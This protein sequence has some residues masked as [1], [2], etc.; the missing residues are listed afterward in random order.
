[1]RGPKLVGYPPTGPAL[2]GRLLA[3]LFRVA[4]GGRRRDVDLGGRRAT[5]ASRASSPTRSAA[6]RRRSTAAG[7]RRTAAC[8]SSIAATSSCSTPSRARAARSR[9]P[10]ATKANPRWARRESAITFTRDNN[11][12]VVPL[13]SGEIAQLT[14]VQPRKRDPRDTDSQK[15][16]KAEEHEADRAHA[17]S[18]RRRRRRPRRRTRPT[19]CRSSSSPTG[20]RR[21]ICSSRPTAS[22]SSCSW[23]SA[24]TPPSGPTCRTTSPSRAT[25]RTSRRAPSSATRRTSRSLAVMNLDDRQDACSAPTDTETDE[26]HQGRA[27]LGDAGAVRRRRAGGGARARREQQGSLA[28]RRRSGERQGPRPRHAARRCVGARG[29]RLRPVDPSF[30][31]L[32][33]QKH[34]WFLS[35]RDGWMH[36]YSRRCDRARSRPR[37]S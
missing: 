26:G 19:R 5:A 1:M 3:P 30:G 15:F 22:T 21:P 13:D 36:L 35:E 20:S 12:F 11:L 17:R 28:G 8:S 7:T 32:P 6:A 23:S 25:P 31:L 24:P 34:V 9:A 37:V 27:P 10:P 33:D 29:R 16:I 14:D 18:R 4:P 2:V